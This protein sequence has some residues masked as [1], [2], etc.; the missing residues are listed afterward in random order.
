MYRIGINSNTTLVNVK[1]KAC[2]YK[3]NLSDIQIQHLLMLNKNFFAI[4]KNVFPIQIQHL[5][6]LN[7]QQQ[8]MQQALIEFKYNTC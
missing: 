7:G 6:M 3:Y 4:S 8:M 2:L 5:L 1:L